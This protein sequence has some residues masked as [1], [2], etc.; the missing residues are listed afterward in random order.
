VRPDAGQGDLFAPREA[1]GRLIALA[2]ANSFYASCEKAVD[3]RLAGRPVV[4][5]S[6]NDGCAIA[7]S[8]EAK[9]LGIRMGDPWFRIRERCARDGIVVL[10]SNYALYGDMSRRINAVY[11]EMAPEVETYS[12]DESFLDLTGMPLGAGGPAAFGQEIRA[13]VMRATGIPTCVGFGGSKTLAKLANRSAKGDASLH[14]VCDLTDPEALEA[15][16]SRMDLSEVWGIGEAK[17]SK[18]HGLGL[19]TVADLRGM[20]LAHARQ[21]LT[22]VGERTVRELRGIACS[23]V[24]TVEAPKKSLAV[25]RS[26]GRRVLDLRGVGEAVSKHAA[27]AAEKLRGEGMAA[28]SMT[29]FAE[30]SRHDEARYGGSVRV[31]FPDP[32]DDGREMVKAALAAAARLYR[33]GYR[34][35]KAG[36]VLDGLVPRASAQRPLFDRRDA[37][38]S[39]RLM[40]ALDGINARYGRDTVYLAAQ[41]IERPWATRFERLSGLSTTR[42]RDLPVIDADAPFLGTASPGWTLAEVM[43]TPVPDPRPARPADPIAAVPVAVAAAPLLVPTAALTPLGLRV[44]R[45]LSGR[46]PVRKSHVAALVGIGRGSGIRMVTRLAAEGHLVEVTPGWFGVPASAPAPS[47]PEARIG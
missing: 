9:A 5:L 20:D 18:L 28:T 46:P 13:R 6:N 16:L 11:R 33:P 38:R 43:A 40:R 23:P 19:R 26:F 27:R 30:T 42:I 32:T 47:G 44:M 4:V 24:A 22:V 45:A 21:T 41:G 36:V 29:V 3:P 39:D 15:C 14:G 1:T 25:T 31:E 8:P 37:E 10:S 12:I 17:A 2:D 7:R 34:Y 35:A